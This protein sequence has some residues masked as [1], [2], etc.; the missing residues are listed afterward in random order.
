[1]SARR[2]A[3]GS[4]VLSV[5]TT[6]VACGHVADSQPPAASSSGAGGARTDGGLGGEGGAAGLA[7]LSCISQGAVGAVSDAAIL[8]ASG[9]VASVA[10]EGIFYVHNDSGDTARFFAVDAA[11]DTRATFTLKGATAIDIEDIAR[12]PCPAGT[13]LFLADIGDNTQNRANYVIYRVTEPS[14][15][16]AGDQELDVEALP[17]AYP[18]GSHNAEALLVD[19]ATGAIAIVT[20][21]SAGP[22]QVFVSDAAPLANVTTTLVEKG[23]IT[24]PGGS[25][26]VTGGD[27]HPSG[28]GV[29]LRTYNDVFFYP[30]AVGE[31]LAEAL[32][33]A[34]CPLAQVDE[35]QGEAIAWTRDGN[36]YITVSEGMFPALNAFACTRGL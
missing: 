29:L 18:D 30:A 9:I 15:V 10:H 31:G 17:I 2:V 23:S 6:G 34:P 19:P 36:G 35:K 25:P 22:S 11:G 14:S 27:V 5:V 26:R 4:L 32:L 20:K 1:M 12:G 24:L 33:R 28:A 3:L 13:C 16:N 7:C 8:E 21:V